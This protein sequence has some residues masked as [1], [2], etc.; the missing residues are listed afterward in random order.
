MRASYTLYNFN[1]NTYLHNNSVVCLVK[2]HINISGCDITI[3]DNSGVIQSP[4]YGILN[5]P[6]MVECT[7]T[8]KSKAPILLIFKNTFNLHQDSLKVS[9]KFRN[10]YFSFSEI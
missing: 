6:N 7:W 10:G 1:A 4:G 2:V 8:I 3:E 5:Y 9:S